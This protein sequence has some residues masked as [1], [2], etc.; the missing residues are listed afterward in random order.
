[1]SFQTISQ[2]KQSGLAIVVPIYIGFLLLRKT[3]LNVGLKSCCPFRGEAL[4][5]VE[6]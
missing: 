2:T 3:T 1:M 4:L 6:L 5:F